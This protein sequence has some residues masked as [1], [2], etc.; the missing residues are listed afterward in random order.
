M[1]ARIHT[2]AQL[3]I[4]G[5]K[6]NAF[7]LLLVHYAFVFLGAV[8]ITPIVAG[9]GNFV[10]GLSGSAVLADYEIAS[11]FL[12]PIGLL[13][14]FVFVVVFIAMALLEQVALLLVLDRQESA[15][16]AARNALFS[17]LG[18]FPRLGIFTWRLTQRLVMAMIP[19][20][21]IIVLS[22]LVF[23]QEYDIN[24]YL[25]Y[26]PMEFWMAAFFIGIGVALVIVMPL[27]AIL[28]WGL[29][30]P[31]VVLRDHPV[32]SAFSR[33]RF[34]SRGL[35]PVFAG[36]V[37]LWL[38]LGIVIQALF[39]LLMEYIG[40]YAISFDNSSPETLAAILGSLI[41][42]L[43]LGN[44][45]IT[46]AMSGSMALIFKAGLF[47]ADGKGHTFTEVPDRPKLQPKWT[48]PLTPLRLAVLIGLAGTI[49]V[50]TGTY[51]VSAELPEKE[52]LIIAHRGASSHAPE[53]TIASIE[54]A[55]EDN[56]DW[57]EVDVQ[58]TAD[59]S[60]VV[61]HDSDFMRLLGEP[62][63]IWDLTQQ[64]IQSFD[65]GGWFAVEYQGERVPTLQEALE[66]VKGKAILLIELKFYPQSSREQF[67]EDVVSII[68]QA[69]MENDIAIMSL[70]RP[71]LTKVQEL[72]PDWNIGLLTATSIGNFSELEGNF[73]AVSSASATLNFIRRTQDTG[74]QV[75]VW[76]VNNPSSMLRYI[77]MGVDGII[78]DDPALARS[79]LEEYKE[80]NQ[81]ERLLLHTSVL[82]NLSLN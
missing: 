73:V 18:L 81:F 79:T 82:Y 54:R 65:V 74:K 40:S 20:I 71:A 39:L 7:R 52:V 64:E 41:V 42:L 9:L 16:M 4:R 11:F 1:A 77:S 51:W 17:T 47:I 36:V 24:Y 68:T 72:E 59:G 27:Y 3:I 62:A 61:T 33:A 50:L 45:L 30:L 29:S 66:A 38:L 53:N 49:V 48:N 57:V 44:T 14:A 26:Q 37:S 10:I 6:A 31:L 46:A 55:I 8:A 23:L 75:F 22:V 5:W 56:A 21:T 43:L 80:M 25:Q 63:N 2:L 28:V 15:F 13:G 58:Q 32:G 35:R 67:E 76:T 78:T 70:E 12:S 69:N 34:L 60:V 19:G